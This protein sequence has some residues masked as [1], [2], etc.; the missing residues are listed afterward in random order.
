[1]KNHP[2]FRLLTLLAIAGL[3]I[4]IALNYWQW[5]LPLTLCI[6]LILKTKPYLE[7]YLRCIHC[8]GAGHLCENDPHVLKVY[9]GETCYACEGRGWR[10]PFLKDW[11][12]IACEAQQK[13]KAS[14][15][16]EDAFSEELRLARQEFAYGE[17]TNSTLLEAYMD[18]QTA[19]SKQLVVLERQRS[20]YANIQRKAFQLL[21]HTYLHKQLRRQKQ[22]MRRLFRK[23]E[24]VTVITESCRNIDLDYKADMNDL[25]NQIRYDYD[26]LLT[27]DFEA[28]IA[29]V[30]EK[31]CELTAA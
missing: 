16:L 4:Y 21:H 23:M 24:D 15:Q 31:T 29:L 11:Y 6:I 7:D 18:N 19:L 13:C 17:A 12:K 14:E 3:L 30:A 8:D 27:Q 20:A 28:D 25:L 26:G 2:I 1:M 9:A 5:L 10:L 22:R